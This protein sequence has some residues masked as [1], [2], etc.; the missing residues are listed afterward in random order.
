MREE[1]VK[2][3]AENQLFRAA[4][5]EGNARVAECDRTIESLEALIEAMRAEHADEIGRIRAEHAAEIAERDERIR[6]LEADSEAMGDDNK[7]LAASDRYHN[8]PHSP[9]RSGTWAAEYRR[10]R[11]IEARHARHPAW[12]P[13]GRSVG[14]PGVTHKLET[15]RPD[16]HRVP[17]EC[18]DCR[19]TDLTEAG[20]S[21][22]QVA[23]LERIVV[24]R[25]NIIFHDMSC[26]G[27]GAEV[28]ASRRGTIRNTWFA[29]RM[30]AT[31][32]N[33][34]VGAHCSAS[35]IAK[36]ATHVFGVKTSRSGGVRA[37][38]AANDLLAEPAGAIRQEMDTLR[39]Y[40]EID[41]CVR[42]M[43]VDDGSG[44]GGKGDG[45]TPEPAGRRRRRVR[46]GYIHAAHDS[47][48]NVNVW[49]DPSRGVKVM[50]EHLSDRV[51]AGT[52]ADRLPNY[53][54]CAVRQNDHAHELRES[55]AAAMTGDPAAARLHEMFGSLLA[56]VRE[57]AAA[58]KGGA[59]PEPGAAWPLRC[60]TPCRAAPRPP[61][62]AARDHP[63][64]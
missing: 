23:E 41:E 37:M 27:C 16:E 36:I 30:L 11:A 62:P 26:N 17:T 9:P 31:L 50:L 12:R 60:R 1:F 56:A 28:R 58:H 38:E 51:H 39:D 20:T 29:P 32:W 57:F 33:V 24:S 55:E 35:T 61:M 54:R 5:A 7:K 22:K 6:R 15:N 18:P 25:K 19:C 48:G 63:S 46:R 2:V 34:H 59:F 49:A 43:A 52:A 53:D 40:G 21:T 13:P 8:N 44:K 10:R 45:T 3:V 64:F 42:K 4:V 47:S 14:H